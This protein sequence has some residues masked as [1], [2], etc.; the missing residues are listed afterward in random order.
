MDKLV[1]YDTS[2]FV[3]FP[4]GGQI[5]SIR[6]FLR[7]IAENKTFLVD[8][9]L[10]VGVT[11]NS[12]EVGHLCHVEIMGKSFSFLPVL[13]RDVSLN[14]VSKSL[15]KEYVKALFKYKNL[16]PSTKKTI[17]YLHTPEA[18]IEIKM[19]HPSAKIVTFS[20]G[21]FFNMEEGFRFYKK[22]KLLMFLFRLMIKSLLKHSKTIFVL[23]DDSFSKYTK[24]NKNVI[25]VNNSIVIP[26]DV[27]KKIIHNPVRL[28][29]VG[30]LSSV[31]GIDVIIKSMLT[32]KNKAILSIVGDGELFNNLS[33]LIDDLDLSNQVTL[34]GSV[35]PEKVKDFYINNDVL[36][37]NSILEGK[38][39]TI[40][41]AMSYGL[42][43]ITTPVGGICELVENNTNGIYT[44]GSRESIVQSLEL[45]QNN[46]DSFSD[47]AIKKSMQFDYRTIN[48]EIVS[49]ILEIA[50]K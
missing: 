1:I 22:N 21:S 6:N 24:Y 40:I 20:H 4:I 17:H 14:S 15:R 26:I 10:L 13:Y 43:V 11:T 5:T 30:R 48:G 16:I 47:A 46:Y 33:H 50:Q 32:I 34:C 42:P 39:M 3:D 8:K 9:I 29:F 49:R 2:N 12:S 36:I 35:T 44:D 7:Y 37:M 25:R 28:L 19:I 31:K 23:D 45:I 18:Y 27:T 41:E 38:P